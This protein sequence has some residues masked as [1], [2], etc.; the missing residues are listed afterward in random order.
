[1]T[2]TVNSDVTTTQAI[3]S[4]EREDAG[5]RFSKDSPEHFLKLSVRLKRRAY[6]EANAAFDVEMVLDSVAGLQAL[7][8]LYNTFDE[9]VPAAIHF[10]G[11][12]STL[13]NE[14]PFI[15]LWDAV[16]TRPEFGLAALSVG[17]L[18]LAKK[19][20]EATEKEKDFAYDEYVTARAIE[21]V[22]IEDNGIDAAELLSRFIMNFDIRPDMSKENWQHRIDY[23]RPSVKILPIKPEYAEAIEE[24]KQRIKQRDLEEGVYGTNLKS[25]VKMAKKVGNNLLKG[26][27]QATRSLNPHILTASKK[28]FAGKALETLTSWPAQGIRS[29]IEEFGR[30]LGEDFRDAR[31]TLQKSDLKKTLATTRQGLKISWQLF[32]HRQKFQIIRDGKTWEEQTMDRRNFSANVAHTT[33]LDEPEVG[34]ER[35]DLITKPAL[36]DSYAPSYFDKRKVQGDRIR[37]IRNN[38]SQQFETA[39]GFVYANSFMAIN[40]VF[41]TMAFYNAGQNDA[42]SATAALGLVINGALSYANTF[43][44]IPPMLSIGHGLIRQNTRYRE[45]A[46]D[47]LNT[48]SSVRSQLLD[49][50]SFLANPPSKKATSPDNPDNIVED[51]KD[52]PQPQP[53]PGE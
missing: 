27:A 41:G 32:H 29:H 15:P 49:I 35:A 39:K 5:S 46:E 14:N 40:G 3:D 34:Q 38:V 22:A 50:R 43:M 37:D 33:H 9:F 51:P 12:I 18:V 31:D 36:S 1:M 16:P 24:A 19:T 53:M 11:D 2:G 26:T 47:V 30:N 45:N 20:W 52:E 25:P 6:E 28:V 48:Q 10:A 23:Y 44:N 21:E 17:L 4:S 8:T 42:V 13:K 7:N